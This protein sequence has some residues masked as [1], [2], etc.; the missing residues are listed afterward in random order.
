MLTIW[1]FG[2]SRSQARYM[3]A[4]VAFSLISRVGSSRVT[5]M[6]MAAFSRSTVPLKSRTWAEFTCPLFTLTESSSVNGTHQITSEKDGRELVDLAT[7]AVAIDGFPDSLPGRLEV[8][9]EW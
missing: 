5:K 6:P 3:P 2:Q 9:V 4:V 7:D 8:D 1:I